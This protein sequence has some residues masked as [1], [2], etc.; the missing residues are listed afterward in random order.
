M[1]WDGVRFSSFWPF[2]LPRA[3]WG[4]GHLSFSAACVSGCVLLDGEIS[5]HTGFAYCLA[6]FFFYGK[7]GLAGSEIQH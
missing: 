3:F 7:R 5:S 1:G 4:W 6:V 2:C